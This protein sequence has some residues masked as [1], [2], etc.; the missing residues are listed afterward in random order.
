MVE[1]LKR[2]VPFIHVTEWL[3]G[4]RSDDALNETVRHCV[5]KEGL[6]VQNKRGRW[7]TQSRGSHR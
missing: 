1:T 7:Q 6:I 2:D 5:G 4:L 3:F